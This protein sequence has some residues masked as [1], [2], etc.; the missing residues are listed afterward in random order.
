MLT[1]VPPVA[2]VYTS[3]VSPTP[4]H[5]AV[6]LNVPKFVGHGALLLLNDTPKGAI[7]VGLT[8]NRVTEALFALLQ[9]VPVFLQKE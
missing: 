3:I 6:T 4:E 8:L 9:P 1:G 5:V 7:G 2:T